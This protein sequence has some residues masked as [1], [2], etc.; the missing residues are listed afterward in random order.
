MALD[1]QEP[2]LLPKHDPRNVDVSLYSTIAKKGNPTFN[3][4]SVQTSLTENCAMHGFPYNLLPVS[5]GDI[6]LEKI[7]DLVFAWKSGHKVS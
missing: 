3:P 4:R 6:G 5:C 7:L 1:K 2:V